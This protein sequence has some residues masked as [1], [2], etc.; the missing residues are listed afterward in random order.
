M[1]SKTTNK[2]HFEDLDSLRFEDLVVNL[3]YR[4][5][6]FKRI[7]HFGRS[8]ADDGVD[9]EAIEINDSDESL[10]YIQCKRHKRFS[11]KDFDSIL[12]KI[13]DKNIKPD[14]LMIVVSCS[15]SKRTI[16]HIKKKSDSHGI[17]DWIIWSDSIIEAIL[18]TE[19]P[20]LLNIYFGVITDF[21]VKSKLDLI[22][23]RKRIRD[24]LKENILKPFDPTKPL[25]GSHRFQNKKLLIRSLFDDE[26]QTTKDEYGWYSYF[27]V[28]PYYIGDL[29][30]HVNLEWDKGFINDEGE[31][32]KKKIDASNKKVIIN[33]RA[34]LPYENIYTY[35]L[36]SGFGS[37]V[38]YCKY[39][40][41][42]GPFDKI[43]WV[44]E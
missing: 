4:K 23:K 40:G 44:K 19:F 34:R 35:D 24:D 27:G 3:V 10:W 42:N 29:G 20:D 14:V 25:L 12:K 39:K 17:E 38:F 2:L 9:I 41:E 28:S 43:E 15:V 1:T 21:K 11:N 30:I 13:L 6:N 5:F 36:I 16:D 22:E 32:L 18:Y 26:N 33:K 8:G 37:P 31:L 7:L